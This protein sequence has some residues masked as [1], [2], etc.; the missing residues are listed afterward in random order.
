MRLAD[1]ILANVEP[2]LVAWED[3]ARSIWPSA[4][5]NPATDPAT[6]RDHAEAILQAI[7]KEMMSPQ[8]AQ[9]Q[10]D[11]SKGEGHDSATGNRVNRASE[12]ARVGQ[13]L[14][15]ARTVGSR[16]GVSGPSRQRDSAVAG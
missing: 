12:H 4:L 11:K 5:N 8:T 2:I 9:E 1:F 16:C 6:L 10:A 7:A 3:F 14:L 13:G 15:R